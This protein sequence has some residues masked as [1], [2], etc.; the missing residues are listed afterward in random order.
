M[1]NLLF[2][3]LETS[4]LAP[5]WDVPL[6]AAFVRTDADLTIHSETVLQARLPAHIVPSPDALLITGLDPN[7]VETAPLSQLA[8]AQAIARL[9][10][11]TGPATILGFNSMAFDEEILRH[12]LFQTLHPPYATS[13][14]GFQRADVLIMLRAVAM[15]EP[16]AVTIPLTREG[17]QTMR[18]G[19]VCRAN[20]IAFDESDAHDARNDVHATIALFKRLRERAPALIAAMMK[21]A[22]KNGPSAMLKQ[23][24]P[25]GLGVFGSMI[26][27]TGI[28]P[29][30]G[31][32]ASWAVADLSVE[33]D[34]LEAT[35]EEL[36]ERL[37]AKGI[38]PIRLVKTNAQPCLLP[39]EQAH[40]GARGTMPSSAL[41]RER[42][43]R[44]RADARFR[45]NLTLALA[46]RFADR[47][48]S[49]YPDATLYSGGFIPRE[50]AMTSRRWHEV[51]WDQRVALARGLLQDER[52]KA[53]AN[54]WA[55][56]EAPQALSSAE[57][58]RGSQWLD[59][60]LNTTDDVPWL[61]LSAALQRVASL[62]AATDSSDLK[63]HRQLAV[64][65]RWLTDRGQAVRRAA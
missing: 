10:V 52:L 41:C 21:N 44:I 47:P 50:D 34:Y 51:G 56:L 26:P 22:H 64:I 65:S 27:V 16:D 39:W 13:Q 32:A 20:G 33:P 6:Q 8:L 36:G 14:P 61:S 62:K 43:N 17:K 49:P 63:K 48:P 42:L 1:S 25:L 5:A 18:L 53:F 11:E 57:R 4:G 55:Y 58:H 12:S 31:N 15:L 24:E 19:P 37:F 59:H 60:R 40:I 29:V 38:R 7:A 35:A 28:M 9:L 3:D 2:F 46:G 30:P 54:R 45:E 23:T